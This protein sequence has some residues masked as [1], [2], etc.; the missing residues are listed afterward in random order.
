MQRVSSTRR[1]YRLHTE[2]I[3]YKQRVSSTRTDYRLHAVS[4]VYTQRVRMPYGVF[5]NKRDLSW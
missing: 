4:I 1:E 2:S 5:I 3:V